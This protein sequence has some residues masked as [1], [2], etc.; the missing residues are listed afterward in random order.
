MNILI[1]VISHFFTF[2]LGLFLNR[3]LDKNVGS[4]YVKRLVAKKA[5]IIETLNLD[6]IEL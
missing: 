6:D 3:Y 1:L 4:N 5:E 2:A